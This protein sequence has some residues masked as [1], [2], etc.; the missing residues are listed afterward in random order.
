MSYLFHM[1]T[2][3]EIY[4]LVALSL[5][6]LI[7][8]GGLLQVAQAAYFG[9]G[10]YATALLLTRAGWGVAPTLVTAALITATSSLLVSLSAWRFRGDYFV[11]ASLAVQVLLLS[12]MQNWIELTNGP[13]GIAA[14]PGIASGHSGFAST[15]G[16]FVLF[17]GVSALVALLLTGLGRSPFGRALRAMRDDE[18]AARSLGL[19]VRVLKLEAF[20]VAAAAAGLAGG[21]YAVYVGFIDP[22]S[23]DL[24]QSILLLSMVI[25]GGTGNVRGP[26]VGTAALL[27][28]PEAL[29]LLHMP[30]ATAADLRLLAYGLLLILMMRTRPQGLAG[31]YRFD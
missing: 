16:R 22:S 8:F 11:I 3:F 7:G 21:L 6:L 19:N 28:I 30:D 13:F 15:A 12:L 18:L 14:I 9:V 23:F 31:S 24:E 5:N 10:A 20:A 26:L 25:V 27:V 1:L 4:G 29:R 2:L 17:S